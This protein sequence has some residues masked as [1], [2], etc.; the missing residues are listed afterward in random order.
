M[1][2]GLILSTGTEP[3]ILLLEFREL[4]VKFREHVVDLKEQTVGLRGLG[5][6]RNFQI[7]ITAFY[8]FLASWAM[9]FSAFGLVTLRRLTLTVLVFPTPVSTW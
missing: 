2:K 5:G 3:E 6:S 7:L 1:V 8:V 4:S 9:R